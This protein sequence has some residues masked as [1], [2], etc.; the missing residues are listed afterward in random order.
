[1]EM[2]SIN[3]DQASG[4]PSSQAWTAD[5]ARNWWVVALRGVFGV[6][7]GLVAFVLPGATMLSLAL[8]FAAYMIVD[9]LSAIM[10]SVR[11]ARRHRRWGYLAV[12]GIF[13]TAV[14]VFTALLPAFTVLAFVFLVAAW[15]LISGALQIAAAIGLRA[16]SG[17]WW[18]LLGGVV[19]VLYGAIL[20]IAPLAG[21]VVLTWWFGAYALLL[22]ILLIIAAFELRRSHERG[23]V[24]ASA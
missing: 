20:A 21:A 16:G 23:A 6:V 5:L 1:M 9:G 13:G 11:A 10:A 22:G 8:F 17:R 12:Q 2:S 15:A 7:I 3:L 24:T 18:L 4:I 14:G 19:S